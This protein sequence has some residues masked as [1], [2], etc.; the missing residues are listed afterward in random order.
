[1]SV[2]ELET[3]VE[4]GVPD[5]DPAELDEITAKL[6]RELLELDVDSVERAPAGEA[7]DGSRGIPLALGALVVKFAAP[8][9]LAALV[10]VI[11]SWA[12]RHG[13][14]RS[15]KLTMNGDSLEVT[16]ASSEEQDRL[17]ESWIDRHSSG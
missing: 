13:G 3:T 11:K 2:D 8:K 5:A 1:M 14:A 16:G 6:R 15:V 10:G 9:L 4:L 12:S 7:P 17:I